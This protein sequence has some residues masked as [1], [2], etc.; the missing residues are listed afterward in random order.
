MDLARD[1][2]PPSTIRIRG[3]RA[4]L[5]AVKLAGEQADVELAQEQEA[6]IAHLS[7]AL[8]EITRREAIAEV[9]GRLTF[10][11]RQVERLAARR[12][13][14]DHLI[15]SE[16]AVMRARLED[17][18]K[19]FAVATQAYR[20]AAATA[21]RRLRSVA[22]EAERYT[23]A[24]VEGLRLEI[25][26][27]LDETTYRAERLEARMAGEKQ[28]FEQEAAVRADALSTALAQGRASIEARIDTLVSGAL[29]EF[30]GRAAGLQRQL[31]QDYPDR[32][33]L[34]GEFQSR[35]D[36]WLDEP[37]DRMERLNA[38]AASVHAQATAEVTQLRAE[39]VDSLQESEEKALG[40][41]VHLESMIHSVR[42][43]LASDEA[44][45]TAIVR[46]A[47]DAVGAL[48][49]RVE[50]LLTRVCGIE[51][52][53]ATEAGTVGGRLEGTEQRLE[54]H[55]D[56]GRT[57]VAAVSE[58]SL[59]FDGLEARSRG[60]EDLRALVER[61]SGAIE[62]LCRRVGE[63]TQHNGA[64]GGALPSV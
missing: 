50:T 59:R 7:M 17:T 37:L 16:L 44:E 24:S 39:V 31:A 15:D 55:E 23:R 30:E 51:A 54:E 46:E 36:E 64:G 52:N 26:E 62:F 9:E 10:V 61:Q 28:A 32:A 27:R 21:E 19:A 1:V 6:S 35:V 60:M 4:Q 42:R 53:G 47:G 63:L 40:A 2:S 25:T 43:R 11:E 45:W 34:I 12:E 33:A 3:S 58:L 49:G 13:E 14:A 29:A 41:A 5:E 18:L 20:E 57:L 22:S 48:K 38:E 56:T 8:D